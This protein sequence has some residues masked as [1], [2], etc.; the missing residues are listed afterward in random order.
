VGYDFGAIV[1]DVGYRGIYINELNNSADFP[2]NVRSEN[3]W[4]HEVR[5]TLR[6]RFN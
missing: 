6:Y 4:L 3:N 1:A 5:G 2:A